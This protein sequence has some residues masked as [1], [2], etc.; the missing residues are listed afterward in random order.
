MAGNERKHLWRTHSSGL[1]SYPQVCA[2]QVMQHM[3]KKK[4]KCEK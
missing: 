1:E 2:S 3:L 4:L